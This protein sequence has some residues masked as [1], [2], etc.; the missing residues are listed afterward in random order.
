[1]DITNAF[2]FAELF[3]ERLA[4]ACER[5]EIVG[6]CKRRDKTETH[7]IE[8]LLIPST[9]RPTPVF[10]KPSLL[11][12]N[13]LEKVIHDLH[14][15]GLLRHPLRKADGDKYKKRAI[16]QN[17]T[18]NE[19]CLDLFIVTPQTWAIQNVIR[20]GPS[21]FSHRFVTNKSK[22][23]WIRETNETYP[24]LLPDQYEYVKGE[25]LIKLGGEILELHGEV[26]AIELLGEGWIPPSERRARAQIK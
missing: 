19:F 21:L 3:A 24:G 2:N 5:L 4:P 9:I 10:G 22:T 11:H 1:M 8:I 7:D 14:E 17:I 20:T 23:V 25:T 6:T 18:P 26:D 12:K 15:E 13:M 16:S